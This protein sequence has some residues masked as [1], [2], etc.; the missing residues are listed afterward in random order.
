M[1]KNLKSLELFCRWLLQQSQ[2]MAKNI[3]F[4]PLIFIMIKYFLLL[5]GIVCFTN[6]SFAQSAFLKR[7]SDQYYLLDRYDILNGTVSDT[8]HSCIN[9][10]SQKDAVRFL[11]NYLNTHL[12]ELSAKEQWE[13]RNFISK[14]GE[15]AANGEGA[16]DSKYPIFKTIY[17]KQ[18][19]MFH[20]NK[21]DYTIVVNPIIYYQQ[22][23][24]SNNSKQN[25]FYNSKGIEA[26]GNIGK[27]LGFYTVFT[28]NQERGPL[29]HQLYVKNHK[30]I[31]GG[32]TYYK[33]FKQDK[34]GLAQDYIY[35]AGY[36]DADIL[37]EKV[38]ISFGSNR[39]QIGDGYRSL[40]LSDFGS[41]YL[42]L[43]LNTRIGRFNYQNLFMEL[44]PQFPRGADALLPKKYAAIH[45]LSVNPFKWL[46][47]GLF[48]SVVFARKDHF[49]FQYLNPIILYRGV[50]QSLG[51]PDNAMLGLNFKINTK[52]RSVVYGQLLLDEFNFSQIKAHNGWWGNKYGL[53]LGVKMVDLFGIKNLMVQPELNV[54]R[55]FTYSFRDS[56]AEFSHYNQ[57]MAHPYG[58]NLMEL[59][60]NVQY[61]P[62]KKMFITL[63]SFYN[64]QGRDTASNVT[65]GGNVFSSY[66][67]PHPDSGI[68]MFNGYSSSVVYSNLNMSYELR[69]NLFI[70]L[71]GVYRM[72]EAN[73]PS[74]PTFK[75]A[76]FYLGFRLNASRR[77]Y[78]Y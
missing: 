8:L 43:K 68:Y 7:N 28:D 12:N 58:A 2:S 22:S 71:G 76:T 27:R 34:P 59:S 49:E 14:N 62:M 75:S 73:H 42:F 52:I 61:K 35:A 48:E 46:N 65:F 13:I 9:P 15:W 37:K 74:N 26:R 64:K 72:E 1:T 55:P 38:N 3:I 20:V 44:T 66:T 5:S 78:D 51:S 25:I 57:A 47:V 17:A 31:P 24:E 29:S 53:Q 40:F 70:D 69:D 36:I 4:S 67:N 19:D 23:A 18:S 50:E 21:K 45:H 33:D 54:I 10:T 63:R 16:I 56:V 39:F 30:A 32:V 41:N 6:L 11:E 60:L 77:Q